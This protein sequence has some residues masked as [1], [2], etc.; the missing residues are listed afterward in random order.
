M[1]K[2]NFSFRQSVQGGALLL[3]LALQSSAAKAD[4]NKSKS[5]S[6]PKKETKYDRLFKDKKTETARSKF[7]TVHKL[8]NKIYLELPRT[9]LKKQMMLG[10]TITSTTDPTAVT[11][12]STSS[13]PVLFYFDIQD[14]SVVMKTPNNV[15]FEDNAS[16]PDLNEALS[17]NYRDGIWQGFNI[18]AYNNDSSAVVF[19]VT[20]LL[21]KPTNLIPVMPTKN[22][23]Y[24]VKATPK[25]ELS[26]IRGIKSFDTNLS[27]N[28]DFTYGVSTS[29]MSMP[30]GGE[31]PTTVGVSYSLAL[32]PE[33]AMRPRIMDSRI[34]VD[35]S[36]RL[37]MPKEGASTKRIFFS[38]RWNL[39]PKDKK[40]YTK[41]KPTMPVNAIR[42]YLDNNFPESWKQPIR[43]GILEWNKAFEKIGF[44]NAIEVVDFPQKQG[45]DPDNIQYSCIRYIPSGAS[46]APT[47]DLY[48][49]PNTGEIMSASM[50]IYSDVEKLLHK[51]RLI[52]TGAVDPSVRGNRLS[53]QHF[54]QGLKMLVTKE[55]GKMLGLLN[56]LGA[57][58]TYSTDS[59]RN[60]RF[61]TTMGL[62][63]SVMDDVHYNYV[64]QPTD[65]GDSLA[66]SGLGMYDY[67]TINWN[68]R[69]FDTDK[70]SINEETNTLEAFVDKNIINPRLRFYAERN[71]RWDPR[72]QAEA[73]GNNMIASAELA[74]KNY[75]IVESNLS[76]WIKNDED[77]RIKDKLYLQIAQNRYTLF[78]QVLSNV[79]GMYL[80]NMK[81]SSK[82]P[83]YQVVSKELQ[84]RSLLWCLQQAANFTKYANRKFE[85][86]GFL[87]VSYYDQSLEFIAYDLLAA[88]NRVAV[89]SYLDP[90]SYT[91]KEY[92]DDLYNGVFKS[93]AQLRAPSQG[94]RILQRAF[95]NYAQSAVSKATG[96]GG[97]SG[98]SAGGAALKNDD[99]GATPGFGDP[100]QNLA[101]TV[102][103]TLADNS[104]LYFYNSL[105]KLR[106]ALEKCLKANLPLE[107]RTHYEMMLFKVNKTMEV[108]K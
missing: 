18:M 39:V 97:A 68:Y 16:S 102:D 105:L 79:G 98:G 36:V 29:L 58:A 60:A 30:I 47:S 104:E 51:W 41:G 20:A 87:S 48:V 22:G 4:E 91:Q 71:A 62:A 73:L 85:R 83:Q 8:D 10:G 57:S 59:L 50:F 7:I 31:R 53:A 49:N 6:K 42:F 108:K 96:N 54:A 37:G 3:L 93:V 90:N 82:I 80:N 28:N 32:V 99:Q 100:S 78:K 67:F 107:A 72:V 38:H 21:G 101:P 13:N 40:A 25:S 69:Y 65:K 63:P 46:S 95:M 33:S 24:S 15:L 43:E 5:A 75:S 55:T 92:F 94:E 77:T 76:K 1:I 9:L 64:A 11:V 44:K 52:E 17:L 66:S 19:D 35:F 34:G 81:I 89:T 84:K 88:R 23:N 27:V 26:F 86:K 103:I 56:N 74:N 14:S 12:G 2:M 45:F 70:V 106:T 61:T